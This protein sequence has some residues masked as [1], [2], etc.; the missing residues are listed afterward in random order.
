MCGG[1]WKRYVLRENWFGMIFMHCSDQD[2]ADEWGRSPLIDHDADTVNLLVATA[3]CP[4][5]DIPIK[6]S[7]V[8][9]I[10]PIALQEFTPQLP[11][12]TMVVNDPSF[13]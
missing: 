7:P 6:K 9:W 10:S 1:S 2:P 12:S 3:L 13:A 8:A 11:S 4:M 5:S